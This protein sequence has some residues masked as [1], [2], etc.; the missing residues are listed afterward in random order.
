MKFLKIVMI[1]TLVTTA[2]Q[3]QDIHPKEVPQAVIQSFEKENFDARDIE[4]ER[5]AEN[6][7]V[8]FEE[9]RLDRDIWY[10]K[11]GRILRMEK[12]LTKDE[13]P[14]TIKEIL[15][16]KYSD[17]SFDSA[18]LIDEKQKTT[19]KVEVETLFQ[20]KEILFDESGKVLRERDDN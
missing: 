8:E 3:A 14:Q 5:T 7:K 20:E 19:Y 1:L 15:D 13:L 18:E 6:Y 11:N 9:G 16:S 17:F 4:W 12:E 2:L 10:D